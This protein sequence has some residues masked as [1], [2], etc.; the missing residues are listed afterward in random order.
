MHKALGLVPSTTEIKIRVGCGT[1]H[2]YNARTRQ[3]LSSRVR[4]S[5]GAGLKTGLHGDS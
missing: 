3:F 1:G 2:C 4:L 5:E